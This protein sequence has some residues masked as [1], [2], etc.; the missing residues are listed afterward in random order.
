MI[1]EYR[2]FCLKL[3]RKI[4]YYVNNCKVQ[5]WHRKKYYEIQITHFSKTDNEINK[6]ISTALSKYELIKYLY[7]HGNIVFEINSSSSMTEIDKIILEITKIF[8]F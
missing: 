2:Y 6:K 7:G 4:N 8:Y 5:I 1:N 3:F